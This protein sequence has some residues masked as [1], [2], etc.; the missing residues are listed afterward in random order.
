[1]ARRKHIEDIE[2]IE[3]FE[4]YLLEECSNDVTLFKIPRFGDYL[5][6]NGFP[7]VAD[8]SLR[9][10]TVFREALA[11]RKAKYEEEEYQAVITYKTIDVDS[12]MAKN[13]TPKA[14]RTA[15]T[16]LNQ[17]YKK[18]VEAAL[19]FKDIAD[20]LLAENDELKTQNQQLV[21]NIGTHNALEEENKKLHAILKTSVYP[22]IANE[23]LK[24][25]GILQ[26]DQQVITD[27]FMA[28]KVLTADSKIDFHTEASADR[29]DSKKAKKVVA[30]KDLLDGKTDY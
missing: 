13:R 4:K 8:T 21:K 6:N 3:H 11:E 18:I 10:N 29:E 27:E 22:E 19:E 12:F 2:I 16:E 15:L 5:R 7:N 14:I 26:S 30:I 24:E 1:M 28:N 17:Y 25:E 20:K 23:L 9:R